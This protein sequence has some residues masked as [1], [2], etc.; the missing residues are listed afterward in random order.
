MKE[1]EEKMVLEIE[2]RK[3]DF[4]PAVNLIVR[5]KYSVH[6]SACLVSAAL[7]SS[8]TQLTIDI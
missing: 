1:L 4:L 6:E 8:K 2:E 3:V 7:R 5:K